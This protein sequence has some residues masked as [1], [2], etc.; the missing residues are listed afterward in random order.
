MPSFKK[1][2]SSKKE[3]IVGKIK[4]NENNK[5]GEI[6]KALTDGKI[7]DKKII[8]AGASGIVY[9]FD[10]DGETYALKEIK[11]IY[12][13]K[14]QKNLENILEILYNIKNENIVKYYNSFEKDNKINIIMEYAGDANLQNLIDEH[15]DEGMLID[16]KLLYKIISQ[17]CNGLKDI[18]GNNI[19]HRDLKPENIFFDKK[20]EKIKI[21]DFGISKIVTHNTQTY[22][23]TVYYMAPEIKNGKPYTNKVDIYSLGCILYALFNL[24]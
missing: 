24:D 13:V 6:K 9:K 3:S 21:G 10:Y 2:E 23:G 19:I 18:H 1:I 22:A 7:N 8:G 17:I 14:V 11:H 15:R 12:D 20:K 5:I 16:P 4:K